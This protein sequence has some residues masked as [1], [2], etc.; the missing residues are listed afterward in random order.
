MLKS[1][2]PTTPAKNSSVKYR[3]PR[4]PSIR[5]PNIHS[6]S[7]LKNQCPKPSCK[8]EYVTICHTHPC[9]I[10]ALGCNPNQCRMSL[11]V[12]GDDEPITA[13]TR[14]TAVFSPISTVIAGVKG[15]RL[16][17]CVVLSILMLL[18]CWR[19]LRLGDHHQTAVSSGVY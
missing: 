6:A 11:T 18:G 17:P 7:I 4:I 1:A 16:R 13:I 10:T 3:G 12:C 9:E 8:T 5:E 14:K 19:A 15:G 2:P